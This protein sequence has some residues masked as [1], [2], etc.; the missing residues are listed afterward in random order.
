MGSNSK[1]YTA[2]DYKI[3][4]SYKPIVGNSGDIKSDPLDAR[5]AG[6][7][8]ESLDY[9]VKLESE[10]VYSIGSKYPQGLKT[11]GYA[12]SGKISLEAGEVEKFCVAAGISD[13]TGINIDGIGS[14][15]VLTV[16]ARSDSALVKVFNDVVITS[17][18]L[19]IKAK[20]KRTVVS[21]N[22]EA[23]SLDSASTQA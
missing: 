6:A 7:I 15:C 14:T 16:I 21:F 22:W 19:S 5:T 11:N 9:N 1:I 2:S 10:N 17:Q 12:Y 8:I 20:D 18:D 3:Q 23:L 4:L 13:M